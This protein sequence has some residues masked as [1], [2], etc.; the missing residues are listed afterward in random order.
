[1]P[2]QFLAG[3]RNVKNKIFASGVNFNQIDGNPL[4]PKHPQLIAAEK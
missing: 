2:D 4:L 1:M 3:T